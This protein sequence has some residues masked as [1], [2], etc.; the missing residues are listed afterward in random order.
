F[1]HMKSTS[2]YI[3]SFIVPEVQLY[4]YALFE[5]GLTQQ[6]AGEMFQS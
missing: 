1:R 2:F 6:K 5:Y 4:L 3:D